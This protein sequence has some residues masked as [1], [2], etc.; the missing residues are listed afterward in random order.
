MENSSH[1]IF[2]EE[3]G[4]L[5]QDWQTMT[6]VSVYGW[7]IREAEKVI[8]KETELQKLIAAKLGH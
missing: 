8:D 3:G 7:L 4:A 2:P 1:V 5:D 6:D